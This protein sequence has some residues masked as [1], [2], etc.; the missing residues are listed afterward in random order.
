MQRDGMLQ[1]RNVCQPLLTRGDN[2]NIGK[3]LHCEE[4]LAC[5]RSDV[6]RV[7]GDMCCQHISKT[8]SKLAYTHTCHQ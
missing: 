7:F 4:K 3:S 6:P 1:H 5:R 2:Q 8:I